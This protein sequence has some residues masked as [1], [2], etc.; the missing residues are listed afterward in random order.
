MS[1]TRT[2]AAGGSVQNGRC[3]LA[4]FDSIMFDHVKRG[5]EEGGDSS[6]GDGIVAQ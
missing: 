5:E 3:P 6:L 1:L 4:L 2:A